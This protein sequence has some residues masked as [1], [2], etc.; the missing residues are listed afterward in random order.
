MPASRCYAV[1]AA[2]RCAELCETGLPLSPLLF[3]LYINDIDEIAEGVQDAVTGMV[4]FYATHV[5]DADDLT[6]MANDPVALQTML[7]CLHAY[8]QR[9]RLIINTAKFEVVHIDSSGSDLPVFR[10]GG[11]HWYTKSLSNILA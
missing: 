9:K 10:I 2:L 11:C 5:L 1:H 7:N 8:A 4:K 6:L 3:F